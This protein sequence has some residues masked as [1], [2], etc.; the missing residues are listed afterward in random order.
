MA[1]NYILISV[2]IIF[3]MNAFG[4]LYYAIKLKKKFPEDHNIN[5]SI[6]TVILWI[7]AGIL[8]PFYF[9]P[10]SANLLF[11]EGLS[12][13]FICIFTPILIVLVLLYQYIYIIRQTPEIKEK[14]TIHLFL[15]RFDDKKNNQESSNFHTLKIDAYRKALHLFPALV[16]VLLW[17]F[18]VY[19]WDGIW[20]ADVFWGISGEKFGRFLIITAGYSGILVFAA[21]DYVRLSY[22]F[23]EKNLFH[24]LPN[25]VLDLLAK[26]M[27]RREIFEFTKPAALVLAFTPIFFFP[28]GIFSSAA[29]IATVGDGSAS[30]MGLKFGKIHFPNKSQKTVI[31]YISGAIVSF[32]VSF[33]SLFLFQSSLSF[34]KITILSSVGCL[35]FLFIDLLDFNIDDN[36]LNPLTCGFLMGLVYFIIS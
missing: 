8:Y 20:N 10:F 11:F 2:S 6:F 24:Y 33:G 22:I 1:W 23:P 14:R 17:I 18:A 7:I 29:L 25:N 5:N 3:I 28:F 9:F 4:Q 31:G 21:L 27:K 36:I 32:L 12:V 26:S 30:I 19:I 34:Q 13:F 15:D 16:I 35:T